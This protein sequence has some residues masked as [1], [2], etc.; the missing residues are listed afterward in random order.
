MMLTAFTI[1]GVIIDSLIL[2]FAIFLLNGRYELG[3]M[4]D[5][6][7]ISSKAFWVIFI[8][9]AVVVVVYSI[10][11]FT[12]DGSWRYILFVLSVAYLGILALTDLKKKVIPNVV[13]AAAL[14]FW[15]VTV[16]ISLMMDMEEGMQVLGTSLGGGLFAG[17]AF[18]LCYILSR[19]TMGGGDVKMA[20]VLGLYVGGQY[21]LLT[22]FSGIL[23]C[24][25]YSVVMLIRKKIT[26]KDGV[27][28]APF[29]YVGTIV[30]LLF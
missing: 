29:L 13:L 17:G 6:K 27:P 20:A 10:F 4:S 2:Y 11:R 21:I 9:N 24:A 12:M 3:M 14:A 1:V 22:L 16:A 15:I 25:V 30:A 28:L 8:I 26:I 18:L 5:R 23:V 19:K 7:I